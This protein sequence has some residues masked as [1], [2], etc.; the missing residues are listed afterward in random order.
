MGDRTGMAELE[1]K[2]KSKVKTSIKTIKDL[3]VYQE[4]YE[5]AVEIFELTKKFPKEETYSLIDQIRRSSRSVAVNINIRE[6]FAKRIYKQLFVKY[7]SDSL[8]SSEETR[9]WLDFSLSCKYISAEEHL[10]LDDRYDKINAMLYNLMNKWQN[11]GE[12]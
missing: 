12:S 8:G 6:G 4:A 3:N 1:Q 5:L 9:G 11:F 10:K 2:D 7:L